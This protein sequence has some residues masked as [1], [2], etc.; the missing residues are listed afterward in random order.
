[1]EDAYCHG[2]GDIGDVQLPE[3][4]SPGFRPAD[5]RSSGVGEVG[6]IAGD[7]QDEPGQAWTTVG[8]LLP[9]SAP[10]FLL[11][12]LPVLSDNPMLIFPSARLTSSFM[13]FSKQMKREKSLPKSLS[14]DCFS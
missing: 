13:S 8:V 4:K 14:M 11:A 2:I 6:H 3:L 7:A 1:M 12:P 9:F 5:G 10:V